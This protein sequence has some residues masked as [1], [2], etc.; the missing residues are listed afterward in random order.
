MRNRGLSITHL[1]QEW[2]PVLL[3]PVQSRDVPRAANFLMPTLDHTQSLLGNFCCEWWV[4]LQG[5]GIL[6]L[7]TEKQAGSH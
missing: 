1:V 5:L 3:C 2:C 6:F 4:L 7:I